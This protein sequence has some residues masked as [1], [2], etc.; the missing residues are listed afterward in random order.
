V[1]SLGASE[2]SVAPASPSYLLDLGLANGIAPSLTYRRSQNGEILSVELSVSGGKVE[3][4]YLFYRS[5]QVCDDEMAFLHGRP[6]VTSPSWAGDELQARPVDNG[7]RQIG[8][9]FACPV[10]HD[11]LGS[12]LCENPALARVDLIYVQAFRALKQQSGK[13]QAKA[14]L[15]EA[16]RF[17][18]TTRKRCGIPM[19]ETHRTVAQSN[20]D[21]K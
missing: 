17:I 20:V 13:E 12:L 9:S 7:E 6:A 19:P 16:V 3:T 5:K 4:S 11:H 1:S 8:P 15:N 21:K 18:V 14:L 2:C 10:L